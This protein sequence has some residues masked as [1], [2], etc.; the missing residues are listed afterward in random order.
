MRATDTFRTAWRAGHPHGSTRGRS[1]QRSVPRI[2]FAL[3]PAVLG[4]IW[5]RFRLDGWVAAGED[6]TAQRLQV[7]VVT[8]GIT[9][10]IVT[11]IVT[12]ERAISDDDMLILLTLPLTPSERFRIAAVRIVR[13]WRCA[14][15][16]TG[17]LISAVAL[18][19]VEPFWALI[20]LASGWIAF[21]SA[22]AGTIT[23]VVAWSRLA[24]GRRLLGLAVPLAMMGLL[25]SV[26]A[27]RH[28]QAEADTIVAGIALGLALLATLTITGGRAERIGRLHILAV[29]A[30][31]TPSAPR[32]VRRVP[33]TTWLASRPGPAAAMVAKDVLV[34]SRDPFMILRIVVTVAA[35]PVFAQVRKLDIV[36][37]LPD[38]QLVACLVAALTIY[39]LLDS[40]PSPIGAEGERL[41]LWW[42]APV[43]LH[44]LLIA[45]LAVY[46]P[47]LLLQGAV[48][49]T[50]I[51]GWT[52]MTSPELA[53]TLTL[54]ILMI[55][56]PVT[57]LTWTSALDL[58]LDIQLES[59]M[60]TTLHEHVPHTPKR[61]LLF[62]GAPLIAALMTVVVLRMPFPVAA[63]FLASID[64]A[65]AF[66]CWAVA[67]HSLRRIIPGS[68]RPV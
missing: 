34:Q 6:V 41:S 26:A 55:A 47:P 60:P 62:N 7:V 57:F 22:V 25:V 12:L 39:S 58:R 45:K 16:L 37:G 43:T 48:M 11:A 17:I 52:G 8:T 46:G 68:R 54:A 18:A 59:G 13:D 65:I 5:L 36:S 28:I 66:G 3:L 53:A 9:A 44:D 49:V 31:A 24:G 64:G 67:L 10:A 30:L 42:T 27:R 61:L 51:G 14:L 63:L 40:M 29:Q 38:V 35:L 32:T 56:G 33:G 21:V 2:G 1:W 4:A 19:P 15:V 23:G 20:L 50:V